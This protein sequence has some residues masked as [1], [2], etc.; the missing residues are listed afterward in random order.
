MK[1]LPLNAIRAFAAVY[2][3]GGV[4]PA[5]RLLGVTH[6]SVS[7]HL[8]EL[9]A[10]IGLA[11]LEKKEGTRKISFTPEGEMLGRDAFASM[12]SLETTVLSLQERQKQNTVVVET[13]SSIAIRWLLPRLNA[14]EAYDSRLEVSVLIDQRQKSPEEGGADFA[15]RMGKGPWSDVDCR[16][17]M[18]DRLLPVM[19]PAYWKEKG[20]PDLLRQLTGLKFL[21]DRDPHLSWEVWKRACGM[22]GLETRAGPRFTSSDLVIRAAEQGLG[23][24]LAPY[25]LA[26]ESLKSGTL[27]AP[28]EG[29]V[30]A[31]P[32][33]YWLVLPKR[34]QPRRAVVSVMEWIEGMSQ[35]V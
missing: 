17:F 16:S 24:A 21:H 27:I 23:V 5:S 7:R 18:A 34:K 4:R 33:F 9:E 35:E 22:E 15:I 19:G 13:T 12:A 1:N 30:M 10:W 3:T 29:G 31:L 32:D 14:L 20:S 6:S 11:L 26:E 28:F 25:R 8:H 2:E